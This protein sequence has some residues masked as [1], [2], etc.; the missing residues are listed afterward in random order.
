MQPNAQDYETIARAVDPGCSRE[1][2]LAALGIV[3]RWLAGLDDESAREALSAVPNPFDVSY[4]LLGLARPDGTE[5]LGRAVFAVQAEL[6]RLGAVARAK[7]DGTLEHAFW[8][9]ETVTAPDFP[10]EAA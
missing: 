6:G 9:F 2:M 4:L 1:T 8:P 5:E 7:E 10:P 3:S